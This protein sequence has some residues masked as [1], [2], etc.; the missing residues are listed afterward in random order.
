MRIWATRL[1]A[2][3][4]ALSMLLSAAPAARAAAT[5][6]PPP[7]GT[8]STGESIGRTPPRL[9]YMNG[10]V[11]FWRPGAVDWGPAQVNTPLAPGDELYTGANGNIELQVGGRAF[12]RA[13]TDTQMGLVNQEP[14]FVQL[15]VTSG[16]LS[17]DLRSVD[18]GRTVEVDTPQAAFTIDAPGYYR[19]DVTGDR[20]SFIT[21]RSGRATMT[22]AGGQAV[23]IAPSEEVVLDA[24]ATPRVQSFVAPQLDEWDN[25]NYVRTDQ[26]LDSVSARYAGSTIYGVDD[27]DHYGN[28]RVVPSYGSVWV[29]DAMPAGWAPYSTGRWVADPYYGWTWVDTAPWGWAPY[30]H[31][32]WVYVDSYWAWAPGPIVVRPVYSPALVVFFGRPGV[33]VAVGNPFVSWVALGW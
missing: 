22:P 6:P 14:D 29:P 3:L 10:E 15:K 21:R 28:W 30:H 24:G 11:S 4:L 5:A 16:H 12:V 13:W 32:R 8:E 26:L 18:P 7:P 17:L 23:A 19:V 33:Q 9:S 20:T 31:G 27:L 2:I 1:T 25:W